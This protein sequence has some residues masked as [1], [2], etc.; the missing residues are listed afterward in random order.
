MIRI[1]H[2]ADWHIGQTL[3]GFSREY[4]HRQVF[5][6]MAE[7][8]V[9][10][11]VD[12]LIIAGD[13]FDSQNP[14]GE[15]QQLLYDTLVGFARARPGLT[16]I[17]VAGNHDAAGRLEAPR[18]LLDAFNIKVVGNIRRQQ[19][20]IID[21]DRHLVPLTG[22]DGRVHAYVLGVS[23]PTASCLPNLTRLDNDAQTGAGSPVVAGVRAL[24]AE[25]LDAVRPRIGDL[26]YI[27]TGHLHVAGGIESEGA[28]RRILV[29]GQHAVPH[30]V[31][32]ADA[33]YVALG[34]LH[35]AQ[36]VGRD[37]VRYAG[38]LFPLSAT[39]QPYQ[40]GV[41]LVSLDGD[42]VS[43]ELIPID[44]PVP[45]LRLPRSGDMRLDEVEGHL[46]ALALP[47]D[48]PPHRRPFVQIRL[49]RDGLSAGF[50]E[51]IDR[52]AEAFP[53]RLVDVRVAALTLPDAAP[54]P[55]DPLVRLAERDP[56]E[57]FK[58]AYTQALGEAPTAAHLDV[59]HRVRAEV[60]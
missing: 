20:R 43:S 41:T 2:T 8:L 58:M 46:R 22:A 24:Y 50:R 9:E 59:F 10:R 53:V 40:H 1:L 17:I 44:R 23:Y 36:R 29:G 3:R 38:S 4:E 19:G 13:V 15:A 42:A 33:R 28:E 6:R 34:H 49:A 27:L 55:G 54:D 5:A 48:L 39:E 56:E 32:P 31:F 7:I 45:F 37:T 30:D 16:T 25:L 60:A 35:K 11:E 18:P 26:P 47:A 57:M 51:E 12:A 21:A 52:I 14:S